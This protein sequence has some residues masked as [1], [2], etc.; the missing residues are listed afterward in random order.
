MKRAL[1][2]RNELSCSLYKKEVNVPSTDRVNDGGGART[3]VE[4]GKDTIKKC[5]QESNAFISAPSVGA[6]D[7]HVSCVEQEITYC[8]LPK[9]SDCDRF[10]P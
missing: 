4:A 2:L 9:C 3:V 7:R 8:D 1:A 10:A 6:S 5:A